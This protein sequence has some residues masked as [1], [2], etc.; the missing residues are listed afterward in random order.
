MGGL[1]LTEMD[2]EPTQFLN[3]DSTGKTGCSGRKA[4]AFDT[5]A[6]NTSCRLS[7]S[8]QHPP[9]QASRVLVTTKNRID[10]WCHMAVVEEMTQNK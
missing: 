9:P 8:L 2:S 3:F 7:W 5:V 1:G 4:M 6:L 10:N